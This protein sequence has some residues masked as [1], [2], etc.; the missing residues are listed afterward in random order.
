[1]TSQA[2]KR[3]ESFDILKGLLILFVIIGHSRFPFSVEHFLF[4]FHMPAFF[5]IS[6]YFYKKRALKEEL[7]VDTR[8]LLIPYM[9]SC[10]VLI[11]C[12]P[13]LIQALTCLLGGQPIIPLPFLEEISELGPLWFLLAMFWI[14]LMAHFLFHSKLAPWMQAGVIL[15]LSF[16]SMKNFSSFHVFV[17]WYLPSACCALGFFFVGHRLRSFTDAPPK[18]KWTLFTISMACWVYCILY[19]GMAING[20]LFGAY[21]VI[22]LIG[23]LGG[24]LAVYLLSRLISRNKP[25]ATF[26]GFIGRYSLVAFCFHAIECPLFPWERLAS[27]IQDYSVLANVVICLARITVILLL[28]RCTIAVPVFRKIFGYN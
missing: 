6:G 13:T 7:A 20:C 25:S 12:N 23:A 14:R 15:L 22:D 9:F 10:C 26:L 19:S 17:P 2:P 11:L 5:F 3:D 28:T 27:F 16:A 21:Y 18:Y 24:T 8:R 4:S 1:M